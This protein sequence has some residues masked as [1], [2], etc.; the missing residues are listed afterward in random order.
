[1]TDAAE[2]SGT[3]CDCQAQIIVQWQGWPGLVPR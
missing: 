1:M 2:I 3:L